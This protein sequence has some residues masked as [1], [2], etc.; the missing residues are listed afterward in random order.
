M[1]THPRAAIVA[2]QLISLASIAILS[3]MA[4]GFDY[5]PFEVSGVLGASDWS[6]SADWCTYRNDEYGFQIR[7]PS[8]FDLAKEASTLVAP[9]AVTTFIPAYDPSIDGMGAKTN[10]ITLS[11][12]IAVMESQQASPEGGACCLAYAAPKAELGEPRGVGLTSFTKS[13]SSE[14]AAGNRYEKL[15][16][17][18]LY[19]DR[20]YEVALLLHSGNPGCYSPGTITLFDSAEI[21]RLFQTMVSTLLLGHESL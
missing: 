7:Y 4:L 2:L 1:H 6:N 11:V 18:K 15:S 19:G 17:V 13:Y 8:N 20:C 9:G 10:L 16:Y 14:G 12:T 5:S 3:S 21:T